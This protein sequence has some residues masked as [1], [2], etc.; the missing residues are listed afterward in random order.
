LIQITKEKDKCPYC[1]SG[2]I[3]WGDTEIH[4]DCIGYYFVCK[5]CNKNSVEWYDLVYSETIGVDFT[6]KEVG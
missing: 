1:Q 2:N 6:K 5:D 4:D 3:V